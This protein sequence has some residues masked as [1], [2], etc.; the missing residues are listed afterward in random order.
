MEATLEAQ[1][2]TVR[3]RSSKYDE[4]IITW[5]ESLADDYLHRPIDNK[6]EQMC[7]YAMT[8]LYKKSFKVA[9]P[10]KDK[11]NQGIGYNVN[12]GVN[13]YKFKRSHTGYKFSHLT[14]LKHPTIPKISMPGDKLCPIEELE[15]HV[16]N[17][18]EIT[19]KK[20]EI[21]AKM[22]LIMFYPF[23]GLSDLTCIGESYWKTFHQE[24]TSHHSK[25]VTKFWKKGFEILQNI[26][27]RLTLQKHL[28]RPQDPIF[29]TTFNEKP[30]EEK[31][32]KSQ[33]PDK[34]KVM[35]IMQVGSPFK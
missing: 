19:I 9:K 26:Q 30:N 23:R 18:N 3:I 20:R 11:E 7:F 10:S 12:G 6:L 25:K 1:D 32:T 16:T 2:I 24:L 17:P 31:K 8:S 29:M 35:D 28:K 21:Y 14:E 27:D 22:A 15:F 4:K 5:P 34:N 33:S 13:K